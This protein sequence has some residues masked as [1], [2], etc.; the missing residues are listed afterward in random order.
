LVEYVVPEGLAATKN[1]SQMADGAAAA[2]F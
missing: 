2:N 1:W